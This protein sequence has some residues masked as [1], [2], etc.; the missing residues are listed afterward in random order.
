MFEYFHESHCRCTKKEKERERSP[1]YGGRHARREIARRAFEGSRARARATTFALN[2]SSSST[3]GVHRSVVA[4]TRIESNSIPRDAI[5]ANKRRMNGT[6]ETA[7]HNKDTVMED[8]TMP[9]PSFQL[10]AVD[11]DKP[12]LSDFC[13]SL[14]IFLRR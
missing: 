5:G 3:N 10:L 4:S 1:L 9:W 11:E 2:F 8:S 6:N 13:R 14:S 7:F 12:Y